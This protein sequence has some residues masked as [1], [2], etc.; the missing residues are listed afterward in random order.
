[1]TVAAVLLLFPA[2]SVRFRFAVCP[3][4]SVVMV[5]GEAQVATP[6]SASAQTKFTV[7]LVLFQPK[8]FAK[9]SR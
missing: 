8:L 6:E 3:V 9:G 2:A 1:V 5:T 7:T 4:P